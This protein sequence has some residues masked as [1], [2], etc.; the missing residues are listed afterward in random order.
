MSNKG[1][2]WERDIAKYLTIWLTGKE[3]PYKYWRTPGSGGLATI[4]ELNAG[5]SGDIRAVSSDAEFLTDIWS[6]EAKNGYPKIGVFQHFKNIK[7]FDLKEFWLQ[8]LEASN[9]S[10]KNPMLIY[11]KKSNRPVVFIDKKTDNILINNFNDLI[12]LPK[13]LL[14]FP[15]VKTMVGY[16][17][18]DFFKTIEPEKLNK[19]KGLLINEDNSK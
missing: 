13:L 15:D 7:K 17:F 9:M 18:T 14:V 11:K 3:K 5:L 6:I 8:T 2:Q 4:S 16:N 10:S 1:P 12:E 19:L